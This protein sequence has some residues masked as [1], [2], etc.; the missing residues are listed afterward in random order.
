MT[1]FTLKGLLYEAGPAKTLA[2][3]KAIAQGVTPEIAVL[4]AQLTQA[5]LVELDEMTPGYAARS[6]HTIL[7]DRMVAKLAQEDQ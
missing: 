6:Y 2:V 7:A 3:Y 4:R 5:S 1:V